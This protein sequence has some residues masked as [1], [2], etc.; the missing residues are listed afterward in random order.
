MR[1]LHYAKRFLKNAT[2]VW[3]YPPR[4]K[5]HLLLLTN[6]KIKMRGPEIIPKKYTVPGHP[7]NNPDEKKSLDERLLDKKHSDRIMMDD[8]TFEKHHGHKKGQDDRLPP[9]TG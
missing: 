1:H 6:H 2:E 3:G 9:Y 4:T 5:P 8:S 7:V